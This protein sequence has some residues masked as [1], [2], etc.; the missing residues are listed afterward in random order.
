MDVLYINGRFTTTDERVIGVEDRG[1]QFGDSIYE[2]M[3]FLG[4]APVLFTDHYRRMCRGLEALEIVN[5]WPAEVHLLSVCR[6]LLGR[7]AFTDGIV[8]MQVTRGEME[9]AHFFPDEMVP[10]RLL[11]SRRFVFPDEHRHERGISAITAEDIR[12]R[13]R[14][15]KSVNLLGN[16][17]AKKKAQRA[18]ATEALL[19]DDG[20]VTEGA[21]SNFFVVREGRLVTHPS[22]ARILP[23]TVRDRIISLALAERIRVDERPVRDSE[24]PSVEEAFVT[25]TTLGVMALTQLDGRTLGNG[26]EGTITRLLRT[27][28]EEMEKAEARAWGADFTAS[29]R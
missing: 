24:L 11:Y 10:T 9:R 20:E 12:W 28:F 29:G 4:R 27:R 6:D 8:Y 1:L 13:V 5:P 22:G 16:A 2:V 21:S 25:S 15:V 18:G 3:K 19:V 17:L 14:D 26:R 7:T 23:G